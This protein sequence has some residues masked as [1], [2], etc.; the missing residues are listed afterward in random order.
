[1]QRGAA[2]GERSE[3]RENSRNGYRLRPWG[4]R[5]GTIDLAIL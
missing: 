3:E 4:T 2:Y 1:M 5:A